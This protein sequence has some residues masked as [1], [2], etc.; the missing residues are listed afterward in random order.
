MR[1]K[2]I[3][4]M[5]VIGAI[6][7]IHS[8][9]ALTVSYPSSKSPLFNPER[10]LYVFGPLEDTTDFDSIRAKGYSICYSSIILD[11]FVSKK[12]SA[13]KLNEID[14]ALHRVRKAGLKTIV[15][16]IYDNT[17]GGQDASLTWMQTHLQ[18]L[19]PILAEHADVIAWFQAGLIGAWGEWHASSNNHHLNPQPVWDLIKTYFP[20]NRFIAV[21]TPAFVNTLEGLD[22]NPLGEGDAFGSSSR[23]WIAHHNDCWLA[24][25]TD[26]GTYA[27]D[28]NEREKQ[29]S[30]V[31]HHSKYTP[32]GGETCNP[33]VYSNCEVAIAEA[34]RF[35]ATYLNASYH[36]DVNA[37]FT[38]GS[39][40]QNDIVNKLGYRFELIKGQFPDKMMKG[41]DFSFTLSLK[42]VGWAPVYNE[43]PVFLRIVNG[44]DVVAEYRL[45]VDADPRRW[46]PERGT[47]TLSQKLRAPDTIDHSNVR[48]ALWLPDSEPANRAKI[49]YSI[50]FANPEVWD[51]SKGHNL[52]TSPIPVDTRVHKEPESF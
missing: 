43:R 50:R 17:G 14:S 45:T 4:S 29:K 19:Q 35:H 5:T 11:Q 37:E 51:A 40:W 20:P 16:I 27:S 8:A 1:N 36:P 24:S 22:A 49:D 34:E 6:L 30:Q 47:I 7:L 21:R 12:I 3:F 42:N 2:Q 46:L 28:S 52:L 13:K 9:S 15:R 26:Y 33:S 48:F 39:C 23:A 10:G 32:W 38:K 44:N 41:D 25:E 18:Q 31:A